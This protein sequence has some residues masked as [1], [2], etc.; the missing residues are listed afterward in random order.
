MAIIFAEFESHL[1]F[2][3]NILKL[4][5]VILIYWK[6]RVLKAAFKQMVRS[7][8]LAIERERNTERASEGEREGD[9]AEKN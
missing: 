3:V 1:A 9:D 8:I 7:Q 2:A 4:A 6:W 5:L